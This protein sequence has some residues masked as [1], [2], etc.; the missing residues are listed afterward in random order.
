MKTIKK[1]P[2][3]KLEVTE[4]ERAAINKV[5]DSRQFILGDYVEQFEE[6]FARYLGVQYCVTVGSGTDALIFALQAHDV[7]RTDKVLVP[8]NSYV[9]TAAA[10]EVREAEQVYFDCDEDGLFSPDSVQKE[11]DNFNAE[12]ANAII[13]VHLYGK[14][15]SSTIMR[16]QSKMVVIEDACQAAGARYQGSDKRVGSINTSCFSFYP[17]KNLG[18]LGD[19]GAVVTNQESIAKQIR[20]LR[21]HGQK[22]KNNHV[23]WGGTSRLDAI[24]AAVLSVR[25]KYLD[26]NNQLRAK[27]AD[28]YNTL[29]GRK[30]F[31]QTS[32]HSLYTMDHVWHIYPYLE[33]SGNRD[34]LRLFLSQRGIE[35]GIHYPQTI[36]EQLCAGG[37]AT[38]NI[39]NAFLWSTSEISLP[40]YPSLTSEDV[41]YVCEKIEEFN[42]IIM[43]KKEHQAKVS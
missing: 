34:A 27:L 18:C 16:S 40:M 24:Q 5:L 20:L 32:E 31:Q 22:S 25:L 8:A 12:K 36:P 37:L 19:G 41:M 42:Q 13:P 29:L 23:V 43:Q 2:F 33:Q 38:R 39:P 35:T 30:M 9:A 7:G 4:E 21:N 11:I 6:E 14:G 15:I 10:V 3:V 1:I 26:A 28:L 17:S